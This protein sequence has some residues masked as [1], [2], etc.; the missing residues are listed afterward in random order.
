VSTIELSDSQRQILAVACERKGGLV[1]PA[2]TTAKGGALKKVVASMLSRGLVQE[3]TATSKQ[4]VWRTSED[5]TP[6]TLKV[7]KA[8]REAV[9]ST[10]KTGSRAKRGIKQRPDSKQA[11]VIAILEQPKGATIEEIMKVTGWLAHTVR[12]FFAGALKKRLGMEV[13]SERVKGRGRVYR[14]A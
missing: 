13:T 5:G 3:V 14:L 1:L 8:G 10:R 9:G 7:T 4:E 2:A 6:V 11:Q 12:G